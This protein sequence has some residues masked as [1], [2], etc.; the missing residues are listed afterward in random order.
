MSPILI[1][2]IVAITL[3]LVAYS[4]GVVSIVRRR[5]VF[6]RAA[7]WLT[8]GVVLDVVATACMFAISRGGPFTVHAAIGV[9]ALAAMV[10]LTVFAWR[11]RGVC[12]IPGW[13]HLYAKLA[14]LLWIAA[15]VMGVILGSSH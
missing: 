5:R 6:A 11:H 10:L 8:A 13:L 14:F 9:A 4:V 2:G 12:P 3:A 1:A 7:W 15:Y